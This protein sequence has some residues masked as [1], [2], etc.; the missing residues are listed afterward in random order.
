MPHGV[1]ASITRI[2]SLLSTFLLAWLLVGCIGEPPAPLRIG[3]NLWPGYEPLYLADQ[4]GKL[5]HE[6][7][8]LVEYSSASRVM[9]GYRAQAIDA[10]CLTLDEVMQ[11]AQDKVDMRLVLVMDFSQGGDVV[12]GN[13]KFKTIKK[14]KGQRVGVENTA[15]GA[16]MLKRALE[17]V[18]LDH[19]DVS[20][21]SLPVDQHERAFR[22]GEVD[23]VVRLD[24]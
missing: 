2:T 4:L 10:A 8:R 24:S 15:L 11:L 1:K 19:N 13:A 17:S 5:D 21:I 9:N 20:V 3:T 16:Y 6:R 14:L 18:G 23:A 12:I 7:V 22:A